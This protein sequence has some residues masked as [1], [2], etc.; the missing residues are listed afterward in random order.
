MRNWISLLTIVTTLLTFSTI[1]FSQVPEMDV[2]YYHNDTLGSPRAATDE[3]GAIL[4]QENYAPYGKKLEN[5]NA[6]LG[7]HIGYTGKPHERLTGF[8][9]L[10]ARYYDPIIGRFMA[11]DPMQYIDMGS[12]H[13]DRYT[14]AYNNPFLYSDPSGMIGM[15][16]CGS[17][18]AAGGG[19]KGLDHE[20]DASASGTINDHGYGKGA[21]PNANHITDQ[22]WA[23]RDESWALAPSILTGYRLKEM[24]K[25]KVDDLYKSISPPKASDL[26]KYAEK[27]GWMRSQKPTGPIKYKDENG[28]ARLTIKK[29]SGRAPGS[30]L[31][32]AEFKNANGLRTNA[33]GKAINRRDPRNHIRIDYDI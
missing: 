29:G 9:Y 27:Q 25:K 23:F 22:S 17:A 7:N 4:W 32:H 30:N 13:F 24:L 5:E 3:D 2:V 10:N 15:C 21:R 8:T 1:A 28:R 20:A 6:E 16:N 14:Y 26:V 19:A 18:G 12:Q 31:P 11:V 33:A